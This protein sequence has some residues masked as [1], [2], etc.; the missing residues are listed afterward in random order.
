MGLIV[1]ALVVVYFVAGARLNKTYDIQPQAVAIP[2]DEASLERGEHLADAVSGCQGCHGEDLA[3]KVLEDDPAFGRIVS[4][5]LTTGAGGIGGTYN[6]ADFVRAI[7]HGVR[8]NG[9]PLFFMPSSEFNKLSDPDLGAI[10]A[11]VKSVPPVDNDLPDI[12]A[13]PIG[14]LFLLLD[15]EFLPASVIDHTASPSPAPEVGVTVEYGAYLA[16]FCS[17]CHGSDISGGFGPNITPG[18][19][20]GG[21]SEADFINTLRTGVTPEGR[22]LNPD[23]MPWKDLGNMTDDELKAV[24]LYIQSVPP[25]D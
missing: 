3:G 16:S 22:Q 7:R 19:A 21:W 8:P 12:A 23:D 25:I 15:A 1:V 11:Y 13:G 20:P 5:N 14:R 18:S 4:S 6:D 9:K 17:A 2:T 10:I 24:W